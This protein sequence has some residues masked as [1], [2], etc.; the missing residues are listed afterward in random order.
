MINEIVI[1]HKNTQQIIYF[2]KIA[3]I[4]SSQFYTFFLNKIRM[5]VKKKTYQS[6]FIFKVCNLH[7]YINSLYYIYIYIYML[8]LLINYAKLKIC[9]FLEKN[10]KII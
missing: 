8:L 9:G 10:K 4:F 5:F 3:S 1:Y 6:F 7:Y 2:F